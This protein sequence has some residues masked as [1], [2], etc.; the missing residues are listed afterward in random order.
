VLADPGA[1][2]R[3]G[4]VA[5]VEG[6]FDVADAVVERL[7]VVAGFLGVFV[8]VE[9][10]VV[11]LD[12]VAGA[13]DAPPTEVAGA[14]LADGAGAVAGADPVDAR[15]R[16]PVVARLR[17]V[18]EPLRGPVVRVF[19]RL[20][21]W[22]SRIALTRAVSSAISSRTSARREVRLS[23]LFFVAFSSRAARQDS[24]DRAAVSANS[25][26]SIWRARAA[27]G[28]SVALAVDRDAVAPAAG[29]DPAALPPERVVS[30]MRSPSLISPAHSRR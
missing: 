8:E 21:V 30:F 5:V 19:A 17:G 28:V 1:P 3:R 25:S 13:G 2:R 18:V 6:F 15:R 20:P 4:F 9:R 26:Q 10:A 14:A 23:R 7:R 16:G 12:R 22:R 24:S 11:A 29:A 27:A